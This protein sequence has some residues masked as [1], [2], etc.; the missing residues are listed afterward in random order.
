[1][2]ISV[3]GAGAGKTTTMA[4]RVVAAFELIGAR[5][6]IYCLAFT[7][8]AVSRIEGKLLEY[9][10][11]LPPSIKVS[12]LHSFLYQEIIKPYYFL[13]Y[14]KQYE[15]VSS[16]D[17]PQKAAFKSKKISE[18]DSKG[19]IH[20]SAIP[21]H[22]MWVV[23][24]KSSDK[25]REKAIREKVLKTL[26]KYCGKIFIDEAQDIDNN[27]LEVFRVFDTIGIPTELVGDPKQDLRG[28]GSFRKV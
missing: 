16:I 17:L 14:R 15:Y 20:V 7:N 23:V 19:I 26:V 11:E 28:H 10:D 4:D 9:Y 25:K 8:N 22:A 5:Q 6:N 18:L 21:Q 13:L 1:M 3:A 12:T 2:E 24:K 27:I